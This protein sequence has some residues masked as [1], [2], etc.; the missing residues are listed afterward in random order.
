MTEQ[1]LSGKSCIVTGAARGIGLA[2]A[3][4]LAGEGGRVA[5]ADIESTSLLD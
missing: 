5:V 4:R 3:R 2:I 1:R